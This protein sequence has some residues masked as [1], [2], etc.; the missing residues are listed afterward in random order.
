VTD[1]NGRPRLDREPSGYDA[2]LRWSPSPGAAAYR[3]LWREAWSPDWQNERTVGDATELVLPG[4]SIDDFVFGVAALDAVGNE[5][6]VS[7]YVNAPRP[8][9]EVKTR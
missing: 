8:E 2:R 6:L 5:S 1:E 4:V 7:A 9:T 3:V